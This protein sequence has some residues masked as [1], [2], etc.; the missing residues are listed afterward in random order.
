MSVNNKKIASKKIALVLMVIFITGLAVFTIYSRSYAQRQRPLVN[1]TFFESAT[2]VWSFETR[3]T[4][5]HAAPM[6][7]EQ[8][9]EW[10]IE[11]Y[12]PLSAFENYV[13]HLYTVDAEV[14]A[15]GLGIPE[16]LNLIER[17]IIDDG[18]LIYVFVYDSIRQRIEGTI[19]ILS[20]EGV[21]VHLAH[22]G[23]DS[24]DFTIPLSAIQRNPLTDE[25]HIFTVHR[26]RSA[27]G[28]EYY[29]RQHNAVFLPPARIGDM[30]NLSPTFDTNAPIAFD[31]EGSL[32]DG[33]LVRLW[34]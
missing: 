21:T 30:A 9:A 25:D 27:W 26:R 29:V 33:A 8:G 23:L 5:E 18:D 2:L 15:D 22:R 14:T 20:G 4:I 1:V 11:V 10:T 7:S 12:V 13:S 31:M 3:S 34:D 6:H 28:W 17:R 19:P 16:E 24:Y 32:Y